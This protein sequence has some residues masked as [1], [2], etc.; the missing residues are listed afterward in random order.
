MIAIAAQPSVA[1]CL[2]TSR[3][4]RES[5]H[6]RIAIEPTPSN[7]LRVRSWIMVDKLL[8]VPRAKLGHRFGTLAAP[9]LESLERSL[10]LF[11]GLVEVGEQ[12]S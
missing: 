4:V 7:N 8:T 11:L 5:P 6:L 1:L 9:E 10:M 12:V 2:L 3:T